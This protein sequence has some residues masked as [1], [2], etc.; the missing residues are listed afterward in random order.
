MRALVVY[1]SM[2]GNTHTVA[3]HIAEGIEAA[4]SRRR[5]SPSTTRRPSSSRRP[6]SSSSAARPT[7][8]GCRAKPS[9][10][11]AVDM[12]A[13]DDELELDPDAPA[14]VC[15]TGSTTSPTTS[16]PDAS[17]RVRH[18]RPRFDAAHGS[19]L[20]GHHETPA[21]TR[22]RAAGRVR[23]SS[24]TSRT[25]WRPARSN[26]RSTGAGAWPQPLRPLG[27]RADR[28]VAASH[29]GRSVHRRSTR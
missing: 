28:P 3:Q 4:S 15:A 24:S 1:E 18:P 10:A 27:L 29:D 8:T 2:F 14:R 25:T 11:S 7:S 13:K 5:S 20:E 9:R 21:P 16:E 12:A 23:A 26:G 22:I 19:G 17:L 6:I